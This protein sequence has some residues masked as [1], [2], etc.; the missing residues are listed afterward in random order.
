MSNTELPTFQFTVTKLP[1][2]KD[3]EA[4]KGEMKGLKFAQPL[5]IS[6]PKR[7]GEKNGE[8]TVSLLPHKVTFL[9]LRPSKYSDDCRQ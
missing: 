1:E 3:P 2:L 7:S 4:S 8:K 9:F 6:V 5:K